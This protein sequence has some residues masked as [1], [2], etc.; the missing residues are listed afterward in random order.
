[1]TT[2][3]IRPPS[4]QISAVEIDWYDRAET[5]KVCPRSQKRFE[6]HKD[7]A[8]KI[9]QLATNADSQIQ[10][11]IDKLGEWVRDNFDEYLSQAYL[12]LRDSRFAFL[13]IS[14]LPECNDDLEDSLSDL[15][16]SIANDPDLDL[17]RMNTLVLPPASD[18]SLNSFFDQRF[19]LVFGGRRT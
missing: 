15:D 2:A 1:M 13:A 11:L 18:E 5:I 10:L 16:L 12:T 14:R 6:V 4:D 19:L 9:L 8:I 7:R 17:I 3:L